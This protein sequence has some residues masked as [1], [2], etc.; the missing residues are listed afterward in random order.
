MP[1]KGKKKIIMV[2]LILALLIIIVIDRLENFQVAYDKEM[3]INFTNLGTNLSG[4]LYLP[5]TPPPYDVVFFIHGDGPQDRTLNG[6][7]ALIMNHL[8]DQGIACFSYDKAGVSKSEG[9]WLKQT[10]KDRSNE[11]E[12]ALKVL[13]NKVSI[14]KKG[15]LGFSQGGWVISELSK[16]EAPIDFIVIVGGAIDW[17]DQHIYY[18]TKVAERR[19]YTEKEK[20]DYLS[21]VKTYDKFIVKNDYKGYVDFVL[22]HDYGKTMSKERFHFAHLNLDANATKGIKTMTVPFLGMFGE[23]DQ[24]VDIYESYKIYDDTFK[25]MGKE[26]YELYIF[27]DAT[28]ELLKSKY[29]DKEHLLLLHSFL[30]GEKI[31]TREFL[32]TLSNWIKGLP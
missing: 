30:I 8:L 9:N 31:Y 10:M 13:E 20:K 27:P 11:V 19:D 2:I 29:Q 15:V 32:D 14:E 3:E 24:N 28:H 1:S 6:G 23:K 5:D 4:S 12:A 25:A 22:N 21:Y 17:M 18:E 7:Y 26:N 16:S